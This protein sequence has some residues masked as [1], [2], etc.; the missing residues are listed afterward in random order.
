[1]GLGTNGTS[2]TNSLWTAW[3]PNVTWVDVQVGDF[4]GDG[5]AD[6]TGRVLENG[7]WWCGV[8]NGSA[9]NTSLWATWSPAVSWVDVHANNFS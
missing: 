9:F 7:Q 1:L 8:S 3:N 5:K 6:I 4:S 2:F